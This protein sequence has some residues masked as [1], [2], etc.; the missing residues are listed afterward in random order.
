MEGDGKRE[1]WM[2][3]HVACLTL[4]ALATSH[5]NAPA[6]A[7]TI[8]TFTRNPANPILRGVRIGSEIAARSAGAEI[9]HYIPRGESEAEQLGL[10]DEVI[11]NKPDAVVLAPFDPMA[12][13]PAVDKLNAAGIPVTNVN[14]RL[15][16]GKI[17]AYVGTDDYQLALTTARYLIGAMGKKGNVVILEGPDN[18][19][20][21]IAR[22]KA[23]NDVL[24]EYPDVKLL[25]SKSANYAR[26][27]AKEAVRSFLRLYPQID[28]VLAANDPMAIGAVEALQAAKRKAL[29][30]GINA[31]REI[32]DLVKSGDIL[33]SGD[34][35]GFVQG[36]LATNIAISNLRKQPTPQMIGLKAVVMD[37]SNYQDYEVPMQQRNC[38]SLDSV[39]AR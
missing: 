25:A 29:V 3:R 26:T 34:Y 22:V 33:G 31:S 38:P 18:L 7:E 39:T 32:I 17:V 6:S 19:P 11:R 37:K 10:I 36:C 2:I 13:V 28:G 35:N 24:K 30:V 27:P 16:G 21:S 4:I 8:A 9:V 12:M 20:T 5:P 15:A 23:Y 1:Y 14:E